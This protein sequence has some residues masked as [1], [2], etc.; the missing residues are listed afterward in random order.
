ML[1][2]EGLQILA[3]DP[4]LL[5]FLHLWRTAHTI[6]SKIHSETFALLLEAHQYKKY[7][8]SDSYI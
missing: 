6:P 8:W 7:P 3:L 5:A 4:I 1:W 2:E